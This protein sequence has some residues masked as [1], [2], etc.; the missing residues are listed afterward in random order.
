MK[1]RES[2]TTVLIMI[3]TVMFGT[4]TGILSLASLFYFNHYPLDF[5]ESF[6]DTFPDSP[7]INILIIL[8]VILIT[9]ALAFLFQKIKIKDWVLHVITGVISTISLGFLLFFVYNAKCVPVC[10]QMQ[11]VL[12]AIFFKNGNYEDMRG[13]LNTFQQQYALV[14]LEEMI[15]H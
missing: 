13:Y 7:V 3:V 2:F 6:V 1:Y 5:I 4:F 10:D 9:T 12:D 15:K 8:L 14:F 11:L